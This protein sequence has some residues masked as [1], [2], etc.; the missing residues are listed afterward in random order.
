MRKTIGE[1]IDLVSDTEDRQERIDI[2]RE[3]ASNP[4]K[5]FLK[6]AVD[7]TISFHI[8]GDLPFKPKMNRRFHAG[9]SGSELFH[10]MKRL[11]TLVKPHPTER[12]HQGLSVE[13]R[14]N[15]DRRWK[16]FYSMLENFYIGEADLFLQVINRTFD[17][18][19]LEEVNQAFP[20]LIP[21]PEGYT[22]AEKP[23]KQI[24][25][26]EVVRGPKEQSPRKRS[27]IETEEEDE[28]EVTPKPKKKPG[29]KPK[30]KVE[31]EAPKKIKKTKKATSSLIALP[32]EEEITKFSGKKPPRTKKTNDD[33]DI[34]EGMSEEDAEE[35]KMEMRPDLDPDFDAMEPAA[36]PGII[37][38][39]L[40]KVKK[41]K[42]AS[43]KELK[44]SQKEIERIDKRIGTNRVKK[45]TG[46]KPKKNVEKGS[47]RK[48]DFDFEFEDE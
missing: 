32:T 47:K 45:E 37:E 19:T 18:L 25:A 12:Y 31:E 8:S 34:P 22:P 27:K 41:D 4:F 35:W 43:A 13:N 16:I 10:E 20:G 6:Y 48:Y 29:P 11:Y 36:P 42:G 23:K 5:Q 14:K 40:S 24:K 44:E 17:L 21:L 1:I 28:E 46:P 26:E 39:A 9:F 3:N 7:P 2:L 33:L 30:A 15:V 38:K